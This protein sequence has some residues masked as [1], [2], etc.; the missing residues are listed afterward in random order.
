MNP[1]RESR[2]TMTDVSVLIVNYRSSDHLE[3]CLNSLYASEPAVRFEIIVID[4]GS[5]D[6]KFR[7]VKREF[8]DVQFIEMKQ[9]VGFAQANNIGMSRAKGELIL[10]LNP[11]TLVKKDSIDSMARFLRTR[12]DCGS[13]GPKIYLPDGKIQFEGGRN[14]PSIKYAIF[15]FFLLRRLFPKIFGGL[16]LEN[17]DH[18]STREV[19]CLLGA[20]MMFPRSIVDEIGVL[21]TSLPMYLEDIDFCYRIRDA[22]KKI[23]YL[24]D[25]DIVHVCSQSS[26]A[27]PDKRRFQLYTMELCHANYVF[28]R[29][30]KNRAYALV[31]RGVVFWG[32][33]FRLAIIAAGMLVMKLTGK[34]SRAFSVF[35]WKKY[36][37]FFKWSVA[38]KTQPFD[39]V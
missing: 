12:G 24:H 23:Y 5:V 7:R 36:A 4:N 38:P 37:A 26:S 30:H 32:S 9:N 19:P 3:N 2:K 31:Y 8:Q 11:D 22:G 20:A 18:D 15:E 27:V 34:K 14:F 28:F 6:E 21:D 35:T 25:V 10:F 16:R 39:E 33:L 1:N 29:K 17:W 13:V